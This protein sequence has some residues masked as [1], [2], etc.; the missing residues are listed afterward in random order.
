M[1]TA[2]DEADFTVTAYDEADFSA[3]DHLRLI[4]HENTA[5]LHEIDDDMLLPPLELLP[6]ICDE[7]KRTAIQNGQNS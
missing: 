3:A 7:M 4:D 5:S 6:F 1:V 2:Y